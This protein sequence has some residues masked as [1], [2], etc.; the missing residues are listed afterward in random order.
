MITQSGR[1]LKRKKVPAE[2]SKRGVMIGNYEG[3]LSSR[4]KRAEIIIRG[5]FQKSSE[6]STGGR[7]ESAGCFF[8]AEKG[9]NEVFHGLKFSPAG[10]RKLGAIIPLPRKKSRAEIPLRPGLA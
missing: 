7:E 5:R 2:V 4:R 10:P 6:R 3:A 9:E 8:T 1:R